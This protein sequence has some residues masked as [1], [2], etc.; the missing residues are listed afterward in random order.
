MTPTP[1]KPAKW[2]TR[3]P[4]K[5]TGEALKALMW[6]CPHLTHEPSGIC[7]GCGEQH[8]PLQSWLDTQNTRTP[9]PSAL[10]DE[11]VDLIDRAT[12]IRDGWILEIRDDGEERYI[13]TGDPCGFPVAKFGDHN[14]AALFLFA[15]LH[16][17]ALLTR[18]KD[19]G[20]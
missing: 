1:S 17:R 10:D 20:Q 7:L 19:R 18:L 11:V 8:E 12:A 13:V 15:R 16:L 6:R 2:W 14:D 4:D 3:A 5:P 9:P